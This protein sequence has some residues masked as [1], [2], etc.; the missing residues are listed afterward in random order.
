MTFLKRVL[1]AFCYLVP[2]PDDDEEDIALSGAVEG[3]WREVG[4]DEAIDVF[5]LEGDM[6]N[7][8]IDLNSGR[9][10]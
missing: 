7:F 5:A 8:V 1:N 9:G 6:F 10:V 3:A 2:R 4:E